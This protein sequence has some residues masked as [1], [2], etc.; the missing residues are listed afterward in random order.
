M[1]ASVNPTD[2]DNRLRVAEVVIREAGRVAAEH[3]A[4]RGLLRIDRKGAQDLVSE[5]DRACEDLIVA[6]LAR[7]FP[8]D[9][10][11]GEERGSRGADA[12]A[13]WVIDPIDGTHNFL[14][15]VTFWCMSVGLVAAGE[16][17]LGII[18]HPLAA[19]LYSARKGGGAFL[20]GQPI[21]VSGE[22]EL[23]HAR[24]CVGFSYRRPVAEHTQAIGTV[25]GAGCE[26]L[27]L[28]SGALGLAYT[29]AGRFDAYWE[30]HMNSWDA[31]A[32]LILMREAGGWTN[33]FL[34]S[35]GLAAGGEVLAA[36]PALVEPLKRLIAFGLPG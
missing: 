36:T 24:I 16:L 19:E 30:R 27:R 35:D 20:N 6:G 14:T 34:A 10:F 33:D 12:A 2:L 29:A 15:G 1:A 32:G 8:S 7:L 3:F 25:L 23:T 31:A 4:R 17:V 5:A 18:Y 13:V 22:T 11:I 28:G 9:G 26:Y 21:K